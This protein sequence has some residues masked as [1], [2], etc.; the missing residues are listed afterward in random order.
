MKKSL[1]FFI[2]GAVVVIVLALCLVLQPHDKLVS[3]S[4]S[5]DME[6]SS[7]T[8]KSDDD[9][10]TPSNPTEPTITSPNTSIPKTYADSL[11]LNCAKEINILKNTSVKL[12]SG[13][14]S[15]TPD[16]MASE[17]TYSLV[18]LGSSVLE[19]IKFEGNIISAILEGSYAITFSVPK[20]D[21]ESFTKTI[22][23]YIH[24]DIDKADI[25]QDTN[26]IVLG[27][28]K[29]LADIFTI[30]NAEM[31]VSIDTDDSIVYADGKFTAITIGNNLVNVSLEGGYLRCCYQ[32]T[33]RTKDLPRYDIIADDII[34]VNLAKKT[35]L[36][37]FE[38]RDRLESG[39]LQKVETMISNENVATV[40]KVDEMTIKI[41]LL[42]QGTTTLTLIC[43]EDPSVI[44]YITIIVK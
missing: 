36:I 29:A 44:K 30:H 21:T 31:T 23:I 24:S 8:N 34:E 35:K 3:D 39:V 32:F 10:E 38:V 43:A 27:E 28:T 33:I 26:T 11:T 20:S 25:V 17:L 1:L 13:F 6:V 14:I 5:T 42:S 18:P 19:G 41:K 22:T 12:L 2:Y 40:V 15:V 37:Y 9:I 7:T 16:T 4:P